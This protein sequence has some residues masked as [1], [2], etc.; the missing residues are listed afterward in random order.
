M[1]QYCILFNTPIQRQYLLQTAE[2]FLMIYALNIKQKMLV[3]VCLFALFEQTILSGMPI[4]S[5]R[6]SFTLLSLD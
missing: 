6:G 2:V 5:V 3:N 1:V 4:Y